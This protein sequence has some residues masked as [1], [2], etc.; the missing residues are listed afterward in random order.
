M[1]KLN[2]VQVEDY[3]SQPRVHRN[4]KETFS[5]K[6][7]PYEIVPFMLHPVLP[8]ETLDS[9]FMQARVVTDKV[10][11]NL[12]GWWQE[13]HFFF[14]PLRAITDPIYSN[15]DMTSEQFATF[16][17]SNTTLP[18]A[19]PAGFMTQGANDVLYYTFGGGARWMYNIYNFVVKTW[20]RDEDDLTLG[21]LDQYAPAQID[22]L[23]DS[24][25]NSFKVESAG[26][27]DEEL[28]GVDEVEELDILPGFATI[29]Q[30][31]E[32]MRDEG[33]T[34]ATY[35]DYIR[36]Y[37]ITPDPDIPEAQGGD[38]NQPLI[39]AEKLRTIRKWSYPTLAPQAGDSASTNVVYWSQ[40]ERITKKR[41]FGEPGF[42]FG[43]TIVKP[44]LYLGSQKGH[45]SG[46][47]DSTLS[48]LPATLAHLPYASVKEQLD[49]LTTG[50]YQNQTQ[51]YWIDVKD[52]FKYGGQ[53]INHA[54]GAAAHVIA[55]PDATPDMYPTEAL[56]DSLF[57]TIGSEYVY[58]DGAVHLDILGKIRD[59]TPRPVRG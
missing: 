23:R 6:Y 18:L 30:Q 33:L 41:F 46:L 25:M 36:S 19:V 49:T 53:F 56:I 15:G 50:I 5:L 32:L 21:V 48:W 55:L 8:G 22:E 16:F 1:P 45:T 17:L 31:W 52:V 51:D 3:K 35:K 27:D 37:G 28:P 2:I 39:E 40:A 42:L 4:P 57:S 7:K 9:A 38:V 14:V 58:E 34:D 24:W 20:F 29:Y 13:K 44:K 54:I 10:K 59:T 11:S 12:V 47:L 26:E 43:V